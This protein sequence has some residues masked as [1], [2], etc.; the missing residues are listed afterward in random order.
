MEKAEVYK[1]A[2]SLWDWRVRNLNGQIV[3][4]SGGQAFRD[5]HDARRALENIFPNIP[6][7]EIE[8]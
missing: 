4:T 1:R 3:A 8:D 6:I 5:R 2:D 7:E